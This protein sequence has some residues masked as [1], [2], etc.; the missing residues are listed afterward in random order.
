MTPTERRRAGKLLL[1]LLGPR[2]TGTDAV[3]EREWRAI[4]ALAR[5]HRLGPHLHGQLR[6]A[7][8]ALAIPTFVASEWAD[9]Y[10]T[11]ALTVLAQRQAMVAAL[12]VLQEERIAAVALKGAGMAWTVWPAPA[13]RVMR[14]LDLLVPQDQ[15]VR[16]YRALQAAGWSGPSMASG[17]L[18]TMARSETHLPPLVSPQ[19]VALELHGH[20]WRSAPMPGGTMPTCDSTGF[21]D[22]AQW[23]D[24]AG[25]RI[26]SAEDM[27]AHLIVHTASSHL[28]NVGPLALADVDY[29]LAA[30]PI[31]WPA[32]WRRAETEGFARPA[33]L[34]LALTDRW[35]RPSL[36][37]EA[38]VPSLPPEQ[39]VDEA[40]ALLFQDVAARKDVNLIAD[41]RGGLAAAGRRTRRHHLDVHPGKSRGAEL[42]QRGLSV[43]RSLGDRSSLESG[44]ATHRVARW[45]G[46]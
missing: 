11:N 29:W 21:L 19:G 43:A 18:E 14:D 30:N 46:G 1:A 27:L 26:P 25:A 32:F 44:L 31:D 8:D 15:A 2:R 34:V 4:M 6:R 7:G 39:V 42:V 36:L 33:A 23:S 28:F 9:A 40:E 37:A 17:D 10:R 16:A 24:A 35:R 41:L 5:E 22:R 20:V 3:S 13:E 45:L 38:G 12:T